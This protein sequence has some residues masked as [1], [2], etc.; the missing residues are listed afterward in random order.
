MGKLSDKK[1]SARRQGKHERARV[2]RHHRS[3]SWRCGGNVAGVGTVHVKAG[4][5]KYTRTWCAVSQLVGDS[6]TPNALVS[7][8]RPVYK[9]DT[10]P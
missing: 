6:I 10:Q 8:E 1:R 3:E 5:K 4:R 7:I 9:I 2:K